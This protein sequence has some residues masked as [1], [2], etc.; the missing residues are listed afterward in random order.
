MVGAGF[1]QP[2]WIARLLEGRDR[3]QAAD[4]A[5]GAG[6]YLVAVTYPD[7]YALPASPEGPALLTGFV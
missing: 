6:L 5:S 3:T 7:A 4:T 2:H 1:H